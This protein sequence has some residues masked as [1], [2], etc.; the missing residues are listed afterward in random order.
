[1]VCYE[2]GL[3]QNIIN[4]DFHG[5]PYLLSEHHV[6][7]SLIRGTSVLQAKGHDLVA[8]KA[9]I[10]YERGVLFIWQVHG[11]LVIPR[12]C[13]HEAKELMA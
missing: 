2:L 9:L 4:V 12:I 5:L 1:M 7:H 13:I 3:Y 6:H 8:I 11:Y 10:S